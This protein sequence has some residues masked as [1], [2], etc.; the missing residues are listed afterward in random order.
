M[1]TYKFNSD[2]IQRYSGETLM[3][4]NEVSGEIY[5]L[6]SVAAD[7]YMYLSENKPLD[8]L[9]NWIK[10]KY[11]ILEEPEEVNRQIEELLNRFISCG[12]IF[13]NEAE[14]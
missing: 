13:M 9:L 10:E 8:K 4:Y 1:K 2:L 5:E 7:I 11:S 12:I 14:I 3:V 6:N